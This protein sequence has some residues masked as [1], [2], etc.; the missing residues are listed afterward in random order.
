M[1]FKIFIILFSI[2]HF[3]FVNMLTLK[4]RAFNEW[5]SFLIFMN[6]ADPNHEIFNNPK[7]KELYKQRIIE[8]YM[9]EHKTIPTIRKKKQPKTN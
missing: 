2:F 7:K 1:I 8:K 3:H 6:I 5:A 9:E 4:V